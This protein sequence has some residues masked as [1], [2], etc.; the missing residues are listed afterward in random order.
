MAVSCCPDCLPGQAR[1][2]HYTVICLATADISKLV[3]C[4][5]AVKNLCSAEYAAVF[6]DERGYIL[7][8]TGGQ[9][10]FSLQMQLSR[11]NL[12]AIERQYVISYH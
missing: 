12:H 8:V 11:T 4:V 2:D 3:Y 5:K 9:S 6:Y 7:S 1:L 10:R